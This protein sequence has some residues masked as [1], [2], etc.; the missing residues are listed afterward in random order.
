M[1]SPEFLMKRMLPSCLQHM[2][3]PRYA[4]PMRDTYNI[5][6][7]K[8]CSMWPDETNEVNRCSYEH[9]TEAKEASK[10]L[11]LPDQVRITKQVC[12]NLIS[13]TESRSASSRPR[14]PITSV[15]LTPFTSL[16][17]CLLQAFCD[18]QLSAELGGSLA[19]S[20]CEGDCEW[21]PVKV[22]SSSNIPGAGM[23]SPEAK[24][25]TLQLALKSSNICASS[26]VLNMELE[27]Q[28]RSKPPNVALSLS[29]QRY[30][31]DVISVM[32]TRS[33]MRHPLRT[34]TGLVPILKFIH[35]LAGL[36][37]IPNGPQSLTFITLTIVLKNP[38]MLK[39]TNQMER[40]ICSRS[41]SHSKELVW[42]ALKLPNWAALRR[43]LDRVVDSPSLE[44][45][46]RE[47]C[48]PLDWMVVI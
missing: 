8:G 22:A 5:G 38:F 35:L 3:R 21:Q 37:R 31:Y 2:S 14:S 41:H 36:C 39:E 18:S 17:A 26:W 6:V 46:W 43:S 42:Q 29:T 15:A 24:T 4:R 20:L 28:A 23:C 10:E 19:K 11:G 44:G 9:L 48:R 47:C 7:W 27:W 34:R 13:K 16:P 45:W 12:G 1:C 33:A 25:G 40:E 30:L 32:L